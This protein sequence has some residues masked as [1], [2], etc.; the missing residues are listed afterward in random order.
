MTPRSGSDIAVES[1]ER[2]GVLGVL[3]GSGPGSASLL[4]SP[5]SNNTR[6]TADLTW[7]QPRLLLGKEEW[8][9]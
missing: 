9:V 4:E 2:L 6:S 1:V 3:T 8:L 7:D 5:R